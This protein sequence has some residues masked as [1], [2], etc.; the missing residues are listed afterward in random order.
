MSKCDTPCKIS[1]VRPIAV[2]AS[3]CAKHWYV[4]ASP[5]VTREN[6]RAPLE[7]TASL[8]PEK[9]HRATIHHLF[10]RESTTNNAWGTHILL[11]VLIW[12]NVKTS[13]LMIIHISSYNATD[14]F[15]VCPF[16]RQTWIN[17]YSQI[18]VYTTYIQ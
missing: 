4:P 15:L 5:R 6:F 12:Q 16:K 14:Y 10:I 18:N 3:F 11:N 7:S 9:S 8:W 2:P 13:L 1:W 17:V